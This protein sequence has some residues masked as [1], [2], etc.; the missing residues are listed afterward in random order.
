MKF[1]RLYP[2]WFAMCAAVGAIVGN[3][4]DYG[5]IRGL[6]DGMIVAV[7]PLLLMI[8]AVLFMSLWRPPLPDCRCGQCKHKGY[9]YLGPTDDAHAGIRFNCPKCGRVYESFNGRFDEIA[10][11]GHIVPYMHHSKWGRWK[12]TGARIS[13]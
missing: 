11:D 13:A 12:I 10:G 8:L 4:T 2:I 3:L 5:A 1:E 6:T 9:R 7:M